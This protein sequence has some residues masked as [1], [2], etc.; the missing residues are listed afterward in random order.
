[1]IIELHKWKNAFYGQISYV[2]PSNFD[3][4]DLITFPFPIS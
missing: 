2:G 3:D 4:E 1:M